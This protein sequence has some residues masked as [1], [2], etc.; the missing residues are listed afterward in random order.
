MILI[1]KIDHV[2]TRMNHIQ[3]ISIL[4]IKHSQIFTHQV[5]QVL[6]DKFSIKIGLVERQLILLVNVK[7]KN[8]KFR[9]FR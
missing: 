5:S 6:E 9:Y 3:S 1:R 7:I 8:K 4:Q 2:S